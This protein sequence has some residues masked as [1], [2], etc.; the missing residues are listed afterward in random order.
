[1]DGRSPDP[2]ML[3]FGFLFVVAIVFTYF[4]IYPR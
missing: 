3:A 1:M 4:V 2:A